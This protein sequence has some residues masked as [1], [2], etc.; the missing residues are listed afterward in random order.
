[1]KYYKLLSK[2]MNSYN[3]TKWE[4]GVPISI[5]KEGNTMCSD[6]VLH[7]YNHPF[8]AAFLNPIHV[9]IKE[10]FLFEISVDEIVNTD[11]LKFASKSQTLLKE[12]PLPEISREQKIEIAIRITKTVYK[13]EKWNLWA[14]KW[15][16]GEDRSKES[17][18]A[19]TIDTTDIAFDA[20]AAYGTAYAVCSTSAYAAIAAPATAANYSAAAYADKNEFNK[21][22]INIVESVCNIAEKS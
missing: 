5:L 4:I 20:Y 6:E 10:P 21:Q 19:V 9:N 17:A 8:L 14:D 12:I 1:M 22:L 13:N 11:G 18:D 16:S 3:D 15:L 2:E 7:C